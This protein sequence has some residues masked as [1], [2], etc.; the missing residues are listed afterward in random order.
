MTRDDL[1]AAFHAASAEREAA[2]EAAMKAQKLADETRQYYRKADE[3]AIRAWIAYRDA[4]E[5][6]AT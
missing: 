1:K 2:Y 4:T 5:G 6:E 3:R